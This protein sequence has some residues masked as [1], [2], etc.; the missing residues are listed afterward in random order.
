MLFLVLSD[1]TSK[2]CRTTSARGIPRI[3]NSK[4]TVHGVIWLLAVLTCAAILIWQLVVIFNRYRSYPVNTVIF[5]SLDDESVTF[6]DVTICNLNLPATSDKNINFD[7][8][9]TSLINATI[10]SKAFH[11]YMS[12]HFPTLEYTA[13]LQSVISIRPTLHQHDAFNILLDS[14]IVSFQYANWDYRPNF[15]TG[16]ADVYQIWDPINSEVC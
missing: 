8:S 1:E 2:F 16:W 11:D 9:S 14:P 5:P 3:V 7:P 15:N 13:S 12:E 4:S 6:P 10:S